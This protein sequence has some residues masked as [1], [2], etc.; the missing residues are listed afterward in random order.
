MGNNGFIHLEY[1]NGKLI[2]TENGIF[3]WIHKKQKCKVQVKIT[4]SQEFKWV[5]SSIIKN[6]NVSSETF[7]IRDK[8][9][10]YMY[11]TDAYSEKIFGGILYYEISYSNVSFLNVYVHNFIQQN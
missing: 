1:G 7:N 6:V 4:N 8:L 10:I 2:E 5:P 9:L 11:R 3:Y